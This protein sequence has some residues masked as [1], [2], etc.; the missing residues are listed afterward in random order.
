MIVVFVVCVYYDCMW[1]VDIVCT[2]L[3]HGQS[4]WITYLLICFC[5]FWSSFSLY[6]FI[7][8]NNTWWH[9]FSWYS[10][11]L[12]HKLEQM[13]TW[14]SNIIVCIR[15]DHESILKSCLQ[16]KSFHFHRKY[17]VSYC[18]GHVVKKST[19]LPLTFVLKSH[20]QNI[21]SSISRMV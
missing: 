14:T 4:I 15:N 18:I 11:C 9:T 2:L 16:A 17:S 12:H 19:V 21:T 13:V 1:C 5:C 6:E 8:H 7:N 3:L 20:A 10:L